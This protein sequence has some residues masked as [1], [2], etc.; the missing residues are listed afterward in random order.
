MNQ[1]ERIKKMQQII[2][3]AWMD[4]GF[5]QRLLSNPGLAL[6]EEGVEMPPDVEVR[7][8]ENTA[9]VL[10]FVLPAKPSREE[11]SDEQLTNVAGGGAFCECFSI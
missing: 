11:L 2:A 6:K 9:K 7:I 5:K 8:A 3:K 1:Q 4:E 10:H